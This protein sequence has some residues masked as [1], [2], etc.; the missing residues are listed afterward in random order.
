MALANILPG[1]LCTA[2]V[3]FRLYARPNR[4]VGF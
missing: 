1:R 4:T 3:S 2:P